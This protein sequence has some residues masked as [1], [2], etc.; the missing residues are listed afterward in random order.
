MSV[1][2]NTADSDRDETATAQF[3]KLLGV[4]LLHAAAILLVFNSRPD[5]PDEPPM[6]RMDV[7]TIV[8]EIKRPEPPKQLLEP[9]RLLVR[10]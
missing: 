5:K 6:V 7:R 9:P 10:K 1:Y 2:V 8:E 3:A 4:V